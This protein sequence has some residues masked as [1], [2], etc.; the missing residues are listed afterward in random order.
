MALHGVIQGRT[1]YLESD[2]GL[3]DGSRVEVEVRVVSASD[4]AL[5][6]RLRELEAQGLIRLPTNPLSP[7]PPLPEPVRISGEPLSQTIIEERR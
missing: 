1:I 7:P 6:E 5:L 4:A 2:P 3:P